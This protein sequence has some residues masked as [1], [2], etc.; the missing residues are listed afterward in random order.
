MFIAFPTA[1]EVTADKR[2]I[3]KRRGDYNHLGFALQCRSTKFEQDYTGGERLPKTRILR[4]LAAAALVGSMAVFGAGAAAAAPAPLTLQYTCSFPL[5][6]DQ[7]MTASV[8][9]NASDPRVV[10]QA[11]PRLPVNASATISS[12]VRQALALVGATTVEG[13]AD[14]AAVVVAPQG[15]ISDTVPLNV[16]VTDVPASGSMTF[17]ASGTLPLPVF[18][19]PGNAKITV[20]GRLTLHFTPRNASGGLTML[21]KVN[22]SCELD[23]GQNNVLASFQI[24]S[25]GGSPVAS[26]IPTAGTVSPSTSAS[27]SAPATGRAASVARTQEPRTP[28]AVRRR[29]QLQAPRALFPPP[30]PRPAARALWPRCSRSSAS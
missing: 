12:T 6:G 21:G 18:G 3:A 24:L 10:G 23:P 7:P 28:Q 16:P 11:T 9:R 2:L 17:Q 25:A 1:E 20:G 27:A 13:T 29:P 19:R 26:G 22:T 14:A 30:P 4:M 15:D 8:V 5:I